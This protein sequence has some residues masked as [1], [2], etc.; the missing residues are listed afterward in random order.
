MGFHICWVAVRGK[1]AQDIYAG[2]RLQPTQQTE[3]LPESPIVGASLPDGWTLLFANDPDELPVLDPEPL[4]KHSLG[5]ELVACFVEEGAMISC[6]VQFR[7]GKELWWVAHD[8]AQ[9]LEHLEERGVFP[10]PYASIKA[11]VLK[12]QQS[13]DGGVDHVFDA[14]VELARSLVGFRH[15]TA[16]EGTIFTVLESRR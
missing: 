15:D 6:A 1:P 2:F 12:Q 9:G 16:D 8:S 10:P 5:C 7:N 3:E 11:S 4:A 13:S 14:P